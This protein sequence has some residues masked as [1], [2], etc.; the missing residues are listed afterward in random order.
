LGNNADVAAVGKIV[1]AATEEYNRKL[2]ASACTRPLQPARQ[3][4]QTVPPSRFSEKQ[5]RQSRYDGALEVDGRN[6]RTLIKI[7]SSEPLAHIAREERT[8]AHSN[9][10]P[11]HHYT[12]VP[13]T[14]CQLSTLPYYQRPQSFIS[15]FPLSI[16]GEV[17]DSG[18]E[19]LP[20]MPWVLK[21]GILQEFVQI[22]GEPATPENIEEDARFFEECFCRDARFLHAHPGDQDCSSPR[23][24]PPPPKNL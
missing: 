22:S 16:E 23:V 10:L 21:N 15:R 5:Q 14:G 1:Q 7:T 12:E 8:A 13:L 19:Q 17:L 18:A 11:R 24:N 6:E 2:I 4:G 9:R 20:G 3:L